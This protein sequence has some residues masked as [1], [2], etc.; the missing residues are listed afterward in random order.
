MIFRVAALIAVGVA[1]T[2]CSKQGCL[3][4]GAGCRVAEPCPSVKLTCD[5]GSAESLSIEPIADAPDRPGG[6]DAIGA[7]GDVRMRNAFTDVVVAGIG[8]QTNLDPGGGS[9]VDLATPGLKNDAMNQILTVTGILPDDAALYTSLEVIDERPKRVAIQVRGTLQNRPEI[10]IATLYELTPCDRGVRARTEIINTGSETQLWL[11]GDGFWWGN[12]EP[13]PFAPGK[14]SG[15]QHKPF[16]LL[17]VNDVIRSFPY[18]SANSHWGDEAIGGDAVSY[19]AVSCTDP[20]MSGFHS[21]QV[22]FAGMPQT[23]VPPRGYLTFD[24]YFAVTADRSIAGA[25]D[26]ALEIRRQVL[27]EKYVTLTGTVERAGALRLDGERETNI[28]ISEGKET[29]DPADRTP[30]TTVVPDADGEFSFRVPSGKDYLVEVHSFGRKVI[31]KPFAKVNEDK[32]LGAFVLPS[33]AQVSFDVRDAVTDA[34]IDAE[35]F[36]VPADDATRA[37]VEGSLLGQFGACSPWLG[38][39]PGASPACNRILVHAG[40]ATAEVPIG[41]FHFYAFHGPFSTLGRE[42]ASLNAAAPRTFSFKLKPLPL[43]LTNTVSADLHVHGAA[44]FDSSIPDFDRVLSF[45]ASSLDVIVA[46]DHDVVYDYAQVANALGLSAK[47]TTITGVETTGHI[48]FM[49]I[50]NSSLPLVIGHYNFWPLRYDPLSPR[51]G[52]PFDEFVEPGE[53]MDRATALRDPLVAEPLIELNHP[54]ASAEFG[55]D[56]GFPRAL[57]LDTRKDLPAADDG[58]SAGMYVRKKAG[59]VHFNNGQHA[60]EVMNGSQNDTLLQYRAF[61]WFVLNQGQL[62]TGTANSDSHSLTDNTVG[63][64]RNLVAAGTMAGALFDVNAFNDAIR[65]G[66]VLGTNGPIIEATVEGAQGDRGWGLAPFKPK[67]GALVKVKVSSAPWVPVTEVR[68]IV[69]GKK[70]KTVQATV[71]SAA[72]PFGEAE[73][74]RYDGAVPLAELLTG[75]AGDAWLV[76]EAGSPLL[77]TGDL[78][79]GLDGDPDGIPDTTDNNGDGVVDQKDLGKDQKIG[80][81]NNP[82]EPKPTEAGF[83]FAQITGGGY[84]FAFTN[85]FVLDRNGDGKFTGPGVA[86]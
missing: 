69:N 45:S 73:L 72:D 62:V 43:P 84:P 33:T 20:S 49:R 21:S 65:A 28:L 7:R 71:V 6:V 79:G 27:G 57:S 2:G 38:P 54:W 60:Q 30:W 82:A 68:F 56:L 70:V 46:T 58:T 59:G 47:M 51:N 25:T 5:E 42:T 9:L 24:R 16:N 14:G 66:K 35:I 32:S 31:A 64:P 10:Q 29:D 26:L 34:P 67:D 44:S 86:K 81:L 1:L 13:L 74:V 19:S 76:V 4:G 77:L 41:N 23:V 22:S 83:H 61:W 50:P 12:R 48:P 3:S 36:V 11:L 63:M 55:R 8:D 15:W 39:P 52:G 53:L 85:P 37:A 40:L 75:V 78:G 17:T 18:M 80:P